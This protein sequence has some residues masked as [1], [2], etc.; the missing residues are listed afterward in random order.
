MIILL[1][2][3]VTNILSL[4]FQSIIKFHIFVR[5]LSMHASCMHQF[6]QGTCLS[7]STLLKELCQ[8]TRRFKKTGSPSP[9]I[10]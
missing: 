3:E 6:T 2:L 7:L 1:K 10:K 5:L 4:S 8:G 9:V